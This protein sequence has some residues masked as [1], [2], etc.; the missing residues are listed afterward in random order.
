MNFS[1]QEMP[2]YQKNVSQNPVFVTT[3]MI[4]QM[5]L[6]KQTVTVSQCFRHV[7]QRVVNVS[8]ISNCVITSQIVRMEAMNQIVTAMDSGEAICSL[9]YHSTWEA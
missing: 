8:G 7:A 3:S 2:Q 6:M 5:D 4:A 9:Q 1:V